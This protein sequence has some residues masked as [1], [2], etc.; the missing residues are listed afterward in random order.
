MLLKI[1]TVMVEADG[2][3][4]AYLLWAAEDDEG[5]NVTTRALLP[6]V[7]VAAPQAMLKFYESHLW[8]HSTSSMTLK[9]G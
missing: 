5:K 4:W 1:E 9:V 6:S 3:K 2:S 7:Y 8:V